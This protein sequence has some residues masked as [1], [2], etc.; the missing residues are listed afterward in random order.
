VFRGELADRVLP[1]SVRR[2]RVLR[3]LLT[4]A[5]FAALVAALADPRAGL[6]VQKVEVEGVDLVLV[7]DLS[8]SMDARDVDPSRLERARRELRDLLP[9]AAGD[10]LGL[11]IYAGGAWPRMPLTDDHATL[12]MLIDELD[13]ETF[14]AQGSAL[15][16]A[17]REAAKLL[18][19]NLDDAGRAVLV[20]S[21]GEVHDVED[22]LAAANEL[23]AVDIAVSALVIGQEAAP[24]P[25]GNGRFLLDPATGTKVMTAPS[26]AVLTDIARATGGA[27]A[28]SVASD[29]DVR[30][31]YGAVRATSASRERTRDQETFASLYQWP[32]GI[33]LA[34]L[35]AG[36]WLGDGRQLITLLA[37][38]AAL[39]A[40]A[41]DVRDGDALYRAGRYAEAVEV[42]T[43]VTLENPGD[44]D[45]WARLGAARY[46]AGDPV[47]AARAFSRQAELTDDPNAVFNAGNA[48]YQSGHLD[49]ALAEYERALSMQ[50]DHAGAATNRE[51][52]VEEMQQRRLQAQQ[53]QQSQPPPNAPKPPS[54]GQPKEPSGDPQEGQGGGSPQQASGQDDAEAPP[55][56][57]GDPSDEEPKEGKPGEPSGEPQED[58]AQPADGGEAQPG[59]GTRQEQGDAAAADLDQLDGEGTAAGEAGPAE[60]GEGTPT[61]TGASAA[62]Q[63]AATL[64]GVEEGRPHIYVPGNAGDKP[65]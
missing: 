21:D 61:A 43:E 29:D 28:A 41:G 37:L 31:L 4:V 25:D 59:E 57:S 30:G 35:L 36:A 18:D 62:D 32:L 10:R 12:R 15:G 33:G 65:W 2:R 1:S 39:P 8:R 20:L 16:A 54:D 49:Q 51:L 64:D 26:P 52:I 55:S 14:Q 60:P 11:V 27:V 46:R 53:Q 42:F 44:P 24:I 17:L 19:G 47:G 63:A 22:A 3:D 45:G 40:W 56:A 48:W 9:L 13:T 7:V 5:G 50:P 23:A 34:L 6:A 58:G 38:L